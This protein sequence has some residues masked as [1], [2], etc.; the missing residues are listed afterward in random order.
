MRPYTYNL[1]G[2]SV[3]GSTTVLS[4]GLPW[5]ATCLLLFVSMFPPTRPRRLPPRL[6]LGPARRTRPPLLRSSSL[7]PSS[8]VSVVFATE[9]ATA[10]SR[11][12]SAAEAETDSS[13]LDPPSTPAAAVVVVPFVVVSVVF[14]SAPASKPTPQPRAHRRLKGQR[15]APA[16]SVRPAHTPLLQSP[17]HSPSPRPRAPR[18]LQG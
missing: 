13:G 2:S 17:C 16:G 1:H 18:W 10:A 14:A 11:P 6:A 12:A 3:F 7:P 8:C 5:A 4:S 9:P 15:P